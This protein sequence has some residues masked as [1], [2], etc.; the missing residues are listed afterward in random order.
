MALTCV[1]YD[2][3]HLGVAVE[4]GLNHMGASKESVSLEL[5]GL[6]HVLDLGELG[7][8]DRDALT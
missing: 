5:A 3:Q 6:V 1:H 7:L 2:S 4:P 8:G